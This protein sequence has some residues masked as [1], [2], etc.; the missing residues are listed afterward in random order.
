MR[1][2]LSTKKKSFL[3]RINQI[4]IFLKEISHTG[5]V[6]GVAFALYSTSQVRSIAWFARLALWWGDEKNQKKCPVE[7]KRITGFVASSLFSMIDLS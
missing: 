3:I 6:Y 7:D 2:I 1:R 4:V 5:H